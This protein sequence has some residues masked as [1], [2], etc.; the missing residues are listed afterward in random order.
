MR[1]ARHQRLIV[2]FVSNVPGPRHPLALAGARLER[3]WPVTALQGNVRL[4]VTA[5]SYDGLL[6]CAVHCDADALD[7]AVLASAL[8]D[9]LAKIAARPT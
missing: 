6:R 3:L 5:I 2:T 8:H 7:A 9:E 1:L 4:G